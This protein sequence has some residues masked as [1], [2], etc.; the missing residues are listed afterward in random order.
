M[1]INRGPNTGANAGSRRSR[2]LS[3]ITSQGEYLVTNITGDE[4]HR[5]RLSEMGLIIG[6]TISVI[7][8]PSDN[9]TVVKIGGGRMALSS[10]TSENVWVKPLGGVKG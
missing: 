9:M 4:Q 5:H 3:T 2:A 6:S 1:I 8:S 10:G 7:A